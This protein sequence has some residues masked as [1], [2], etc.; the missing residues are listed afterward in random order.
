MD[1]DRRKALSSGSRVRRCRQLTILSRKIKLQTSFVYTH[2]LKANNMTALNKN[3]SKK[4]IQNTFAGKFVLSLGTMLLSNWKSTLGG[5]AVGGV[6][7]LNGVA[8]SDPT[9]VGAGV[10]TVIG[11]IVAGDLHKSPR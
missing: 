8:N 10:A 5:I 4:P 1:P 2:S 7:I 9:Q 6:A 3:K 11:G